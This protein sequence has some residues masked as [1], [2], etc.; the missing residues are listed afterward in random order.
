[1][2]LRVVLVRRAAFEGPT[3]AEALLELLESVLARVV[4]VLRGLL[5]VQVVQVPEELVEAVH[6][7]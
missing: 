4:R 7:R 1:V 6:R 5:G 2:L 3:R